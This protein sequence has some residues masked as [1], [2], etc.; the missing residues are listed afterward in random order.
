[1]TENLKSYSATTIQSSPGLITTNSKTNWRIESANKKWLSNNF[2]FNEIK[3]REDE[4]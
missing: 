3:L 1:M 4:N 2:L